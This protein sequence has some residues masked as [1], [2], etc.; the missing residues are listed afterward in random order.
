MEIARYR[1]E[2]QKI[3]YDLQWNPPKHVDRQYVSRKEERR[4]LISVKDRVE[5]EV[6]GLKVYIY[7]SDERLMQVTLRNKIGGLEPTSI[8]KVK[9]KE[10][11]R[12]VSA[13]VLHEMYF[14]Q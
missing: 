12:M 8:L 6:R 11:C 13:K 10:G 5:F 9:Q 7:R 2:N 4:G 14:M 1:S 3:I